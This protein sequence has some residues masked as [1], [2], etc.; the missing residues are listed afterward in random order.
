MYVPILNH[1]APVE[2]CTII[3]TAANEIVGELHDR[4]PVILHPG[5]YDR[6]LDTG[7]SNTS[8]LRDLL[9]PYSSEAI[10]MNPVGDIVNNARNEDPRCIEPA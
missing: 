3:T 4:M 7:T 2:S 8:G 1:G 10:L 6:W 5:D 9:A